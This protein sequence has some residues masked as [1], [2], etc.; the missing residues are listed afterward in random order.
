M[1]VAL[2]FEISFASFCVCG[3]WWFFFMI[4]YNI[5]SVLSFSLS[6]SLS[7]PLPFPEFVAQGGDPTGT[8][9]GTLYLLLSSLKIYF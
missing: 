9:E 2:F 1:H 3:S 8:G 4:S 5:Y 7:L 6:L